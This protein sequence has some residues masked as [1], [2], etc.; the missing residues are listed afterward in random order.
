MEKKNTNKWVIGLIFSALLGGGLALLT[1][2]RSG[3]ET[4]DMIAEKSNKLRDKAVAAAMSTKGKFEELTSEVVDNTRERVN[5]LKVE[6]QRV[7][8]AEAEVIKDCV[9]NAKQA[10]NS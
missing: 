8:S 7:K 4:R 6:G 3:E 1:A 10:I 2:S 9:Q 5:K